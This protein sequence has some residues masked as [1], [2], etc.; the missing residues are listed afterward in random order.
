MGERRALTTII[1]GALIIAL[2]SGAVAWAAA[3]WSPSGA[4]DTIVLDRAGGPAGEYVAH[5][6]GTSALQ[7]SVADGGEW[8]LDGETCVARFAV[9]REQDNH[10]PTL[11]L[12][13]TGGGYYPYLAS[14][15]GAL[16]VEVPKGTSILGWADFIST[17]RSNDWPGTALDTQQDLRLFR[18]TYASAPAENGRAL[19]RMGEQTRVALPWEGAIWDQR[20]QVNLTIRI[21]PIDR[22]DRL[23]ARWERNYSM[24]VQTVEA[25]HSRGEPTAA[26]VAQVV[27]GTDASRY[28]SPYGAR[29]AYAWLIAEIE[30]LYAGF[31]TAAGYSTASD[32]VSSLPITSN[33]DSGVPSAGQIITRSAS[34]SDKP[35][36]TAGFGMDFNS[37]GSRFYFTH[38]AGYTDQK[39]YKRDSD[40][41]TEIPL[42]A[43]AG[44]DAVFARHFAD[45][46]GDEIKIGIEGT[47]AGSGVNHAFSI[48]NI[49]DA[50]VLFKRS[51]ADV[52]AMFPDRSG[53]ADIITYAWNRRATLRVR[54][55]PA[56]D[57]CVVWSGSNNRAEWATCP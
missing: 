12:P 21:G 7:A 43:N 53:D 38:D 33:S 54:G 44:T 52:A 27:A 16:S 51:D 48:P 26:T 49:N 20:R 10:A 46:A 39:L 50:A 18:Q 55:A 37:G 31:T 32:W 1:M 3:N 23:E 2:C 56:N 13:V 14:S 8:R 25:V 17:T 35:T 57:Q 24:D 47:G 42:F 29:A 30:S 45:L 40:N 36:G 28:L 6:Y 15:S 19:L 5:A 9:A 34:Y 4:A 11:T 22:C 41:W